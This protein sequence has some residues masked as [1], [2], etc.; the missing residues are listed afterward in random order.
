MSKIYLA[1]PITG[2]NSNEVFDY[3]DTISELLNGR[4]TILSPMTGKDY[5]RNETT[6]RIGCRRIYRMCLSLMK[7]A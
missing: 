4:H 6:I 7:D 1:H 5:L 3:Y 2:L